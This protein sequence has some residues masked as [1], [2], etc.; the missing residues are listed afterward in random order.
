MAVP[1]ESAVVTITI[2]SGGVDF[3]SAPL[4]M[5]Q[6]GSSLEAHYTIP[7][8]AF[9]ASAIADVDQLTFRVA[10]VMGSSLAMA[11][12]QVKTVAAEPSSSVATPPGTGAR[13]LHRRCG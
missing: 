10:S 11:N 3:T 5:E 12:L 2:R 1:A 7:F 13:V 4:T 8:P 9:P 6:S